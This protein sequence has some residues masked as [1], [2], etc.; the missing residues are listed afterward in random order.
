[1]KYLPLLLSLLL[2]ACNS[3]EEIITTRIIEPFDRVWEYTP[4][5]GQFINEP[6]SGFHNITTDAAACEYAMQ[7]LEKGL[8]VSLGGWGG[9]LVASFAKPVPSS[10]NDYDLLITGNTFNNSSEPGVVWV[11]DDSN[12][13]GLPDDTTWYELRGSEYANPATIRDYKVTYYNNHVTDNQPITWQDNKGNEGTID[14]ISDHQQPSYYPAWIA[15][16]QY[17]LQG[18]RL[19]DN[20]TKKVVDGVESWTSFP[21]AWGYADNYS[22]SDMARG[23]NR[24]RISDAM[25]TD[26]TPANLTQI[27]FVKIQTGV[28]AKAPL[29]GEI[30]T[31]VC[32]IA[33]FR[34]VSQ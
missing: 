25:K 24:F 32:G 34:T 30:S 7:R 12:G 8:Y 16:D 9:Y 26:G 3:S 22:S 21:F 13:N 18:V 19:P 10:G 29:I 27:R 15:R 14:R 20:I 1:M 11:M 2:I 33:C 5:P 23:G 31:D 6:A 4:A 28:N 17:T